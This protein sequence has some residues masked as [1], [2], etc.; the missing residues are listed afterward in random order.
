MLSS[1]FAGVV[2]FSQFVAPILT[3]AYRRLLASRRVYIHFGTLLM[4]AALF[5][6]VCAVEAQPVPVTPTAPIA[7]P[8]VPPVA[9]SRPVPPS[10]EEINAVLPVVLSG[11]SDHSL[12][13]WDAAGKLSAMIGQHEGSV[14]AIAL[15]YYMPALGGKP[16]PLLISGSADGTL[17]W[18]DLAE[19]DVANPMPL[20]SVKAHE[21]G[22]TALAISPD[23]LIV[24]TGGADAFIRLWSRANGRLLAEMKA[25]DDTIRSLQ[26]SGDGKTLV[27]SSD[28][29]QIRIWKP[30]AQGRLLDYESTIVA[31]EGSITA[32]SLSPAGDLIASISMDGYA[33]IWAS[34]GSLMRRIKVSSKGIFAVAFSPDG[35]TIAT[36]DEEGK[37]RLWNVKTGAGLAFAG[38]HDRGVYALAWTPNGEMLVSGGGDK[39]LRYWNTRNGHQIARIAA[40]DGTVQTL[41]VV[42]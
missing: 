28:D 9:A 37:I 41:L 22:V 38:S 20:R 33:K 15:T 2:R 18:W 29:R 4:G 35:K 1:R 14:S 32:I 16:L 31:H 27:S 26:F 6:S 19:E 13:H 21:G 3:R 34:N 11:G 36:G 7:A 30:G 24:A 8:A 23:S 40:H 17:K 5:V 10:A 12:K 42:P 25:H 39:T